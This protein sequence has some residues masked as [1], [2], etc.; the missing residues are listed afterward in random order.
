ML[1]FSLALNNYTMHTAIR[2]SMPETATDGDAW[3]CVLT[4][5]NQCQVST[6][7]TGTDAIPWERCFIRSSDLCQF[8]WFRSDGPETTFRCRPVVYWRVREFG[9]CTHPCVREDFVYKNSQTTLNSDTCKLRQLVS[10]GR[11]LFFI[12][13]PADVLTWF[14]TLGIGDFTSVCLWQTVGIYLQPLL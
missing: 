10:H 14:L 8:G 4:A 12:K 9:L 3:A 5:C 7:A 1:S 13:N 6:L 11:V 2:V